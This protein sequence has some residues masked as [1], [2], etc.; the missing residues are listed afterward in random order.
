MSATFEQLIKRMESEE[1]DAMLNTEIFWLV[2]GEGTPHWAN[3]NAQFDSSFDDAFALAPKEMSDWLVA[4]HHNPP[5]IL[6]E[7]TIKVKKKKNETQ[8][9]FTA[10]A[11]TPA[12]SFTIAAL[13]ALAYLDSAKSMAA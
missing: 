8:E 12:R 11:S 6:T 2:F 4:T 5:S 7:I 13:K 1:Y 10:I 3:F 9:S